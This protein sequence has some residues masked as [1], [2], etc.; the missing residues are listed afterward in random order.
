MHPN[1]TLQ[2]LSQQWQAQFHNASSRSIV[3]KPEILNTI[4]NLSQFL[5]TD[6]NTPPRKWTLQIGL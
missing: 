1:S 3:L 4:R 2:L 6:L 5:K